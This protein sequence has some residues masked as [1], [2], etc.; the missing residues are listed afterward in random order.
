MHCG[1]SA[2]GIAGAWRAWVE[3]TATLKHGE[4]AK[5]STACLYGAI[6][7]SVKV[8][9][10]L[11]KGTYGGTPR[12]ETGRLHVAVVTKGLHTLLKKA[13]KVGGPD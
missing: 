8:L 10:T 6:D 1:V 7:V 2:L 11:K 3:R 12:F 4:C 5:Q 9:F 13:Y